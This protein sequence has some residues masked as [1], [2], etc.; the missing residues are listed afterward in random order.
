MHFKLDLKEK[1]ML[2]KMKKK[3]TFSKIRPIPLP[4]VVLENGTLLTATS[5]DI[6]RQ[7]DGHKSASKD[8]LECL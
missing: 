8:I 4:F 5:M 6:D 1:M 3:G 2:I 7:T